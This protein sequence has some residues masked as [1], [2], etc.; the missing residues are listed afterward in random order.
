MNE[1]IDSLKIAI[2]KLTSAQGKPSK[3]MMVEQLFDY[4]SESMR[5]GVTLELLTVALQQKG[6]NITVPYL[7][8]TMYRIRKKRNGNIT[9]TLINNS[10]PANI[11][12][13]ISTSSSAVNKN[14]ATL[15]ELTKKMDAFNK[16]VGWQER[17]IALGGNIEDVR[18][19]PAS[20]QRHMAMHLKSTVERE[21]RDHQ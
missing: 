17:Y 18:G 19:K 3:S 9:K 11:T 21:L 7:R 20:E 5:A 14:A 13:P 15:A 16:A 4:I 10:P 2:K 6:L 1:S 8:N 12:N